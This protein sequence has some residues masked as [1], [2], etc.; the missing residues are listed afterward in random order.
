M[1][2]IEIILNRPAYGDDITF[3]VILHHDYMLLKRDDIE[4]SKAIWVDQSD[5][6]WNEDLIKRLESN[7]IS[8]PSKVRY[9]FE[10]A[11][12]SWR[13]GE[14]DDVQIKQEIQLIAD[15]INAASKALPHSE[16]WNDKF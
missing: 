3:H 14:L 16:F 4:C 1:T 10:T 11:W 9:S 13:S 2:D 6:E 8:P 12:K 5:P 7:H 15:W